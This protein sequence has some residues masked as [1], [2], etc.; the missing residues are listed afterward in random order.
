L[1]A[2]HI[3][4]ANRATVRTIFQDF[5]VIDTRRTSPVRRHMRLNSSPFFI[6]QIKPAH[7]VLHEQTQP[8]LLQ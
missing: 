7:G 1:S 8:D 6:P 5:P 3:A 4:L 2:A